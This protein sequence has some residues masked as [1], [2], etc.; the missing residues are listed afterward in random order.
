LLSIPFKSHNEWVFVRVKYEDTQKGPI[1][2]SIVVS[3]GSQLHN[4]DT[5]KKNKESLSNFKVTNAKTYKQQMRLKIQ[6]IVENPYLAKKTLKKLEKMR[7]KKK[8]ELHADK[9]FIN[10][11]VDR[12]TYW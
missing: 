8:N 6:Q 7:E 10:L 5:L 2:A 12:A 3:F 4:N 9:D 11:N 1:K